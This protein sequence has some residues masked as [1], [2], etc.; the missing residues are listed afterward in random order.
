MTQKA[1]I[2]GPMSGKD[3]FNFEAFNK[4]ESWLDC[5]TKYTIFNPA[6]EGDLDRDG[7]PTK[8][9]HEYLR[10]AFK[11]LSQCDVIVLLDGW[12]DSSGARAELRAAVEIGLTIR[13]FRPDIEGIPRVDNPETVLREAES[14]I[15]GVRN[16]DYGHPAE[17]F[18]KTAKMW[19][20][21]FHDKLSE[22]LEAKD[23]ALAMCC[24]KMSREMN[25]PKRDNIVDLAGY[26]GTIEMIKEKKGENNE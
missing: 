24:V 5:N 13:E 14:L 12:K 17:D 3:G 4:C 22:D 6:K 10:R 8:Q 2:A 1:Y 16:S 19:S 15:R 23:V 21:L 11:E 25:K 7:N 20:G 9:R 26:A 18:A